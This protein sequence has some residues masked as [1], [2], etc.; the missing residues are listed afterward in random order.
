MSIKGVYLHILLCCGSPSSYS[1]YRQIR[2]ESLQSV[3]QSCAI[4]FIIRYNSWGHNSDSSMT[5][6]TCAQLHT[7]D[8]LHLIRSLNE[9]ALR[10]EKGWACWGGRKREREKC[11]RSVWLKTLCPLQKAWGWEW[12]L[13]RIQQAEHMDAV[14]LLSQIETAAALTAT[15]KWEPVKAK[16]LTLRAP[17][18]QIKRAPTHKRMLTRPSW[19]AVSHTRGEKSGSPLAMTSHTWVQS[20]AGGLTATPHALEKGEGPE[21]HR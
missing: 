13:S 2:D 4:V 14:Q 17:S 10:Q 9:L 7:R 21:L 12:S 1:F 20:L 16:Q 8:V 18:P 11:K 5:N 19:R 15:D 3:V 6:N